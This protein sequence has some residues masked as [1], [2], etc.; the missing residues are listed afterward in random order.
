MKRA[1]LRAG[2][3]SL[4]LF[5]ISSASAQVPDLDTVLRFESRQ[6]GQILHGWGGGPAGTIFLDTT[7]VHSGSGAAHLVRKANSP[8]VFSTITKMVPADF[9][10]EWIELRGFLRT[11]NVSGFAGLWLRVDGRNGSLQFDNMYERSLKGTTEW[12]EYAVRLPLDS[13]A[14]EIFFGVLVEGEGEVWADDLQLTVEDK[15]VSEATRR[16]IEPTV[17]DTDREFDGGSG[18][19]VTTLTPLQT[20]NLAVLGKV[21]GF[22]KY[23]HP[24]VTAGEHHWDYELFRVLP[25]IL[26]ASDYSERNHTILAWIETIGIPGPC[27]ACAPEP[28]EPHLLP[29]LDWINDS[30][31][32]GAVL[33]GQLQTIYERR[34][35]DPEQFY[36]TQVSGVGNPVFEQELAYDAHQPPDAGFRFLSLLRLW[37]IVEYWFPYRDLLEDDWDAVLRDFLPRFTAAEG[38]DTYQLEVLSLLVRL[39]DTHANL[40]SALNLRPPRGD[41]RWPAA[42]R[43]AENQFVVA[44][45]VSTDSSYTPNLEIGDVIRA[46]DAIPVDSL[47]AEWSPYYAASNET[48]RLRDIARYMPRGDC[49]ES[50]VT[51]LRQGK[52]LTVDVPRVTTADPRPL[53]HDRPGQ[54]FQLLS[55]EV[56]YLKLSSVAAEDIGSYIERATGTDGLVI[57]IRNYPSEFVVFA[58]GSRLVDEPTPFARFTIGDPANPGAFVWTNPVS[59]EPQQPVYTGKVAILVDESSLSQAEYTAMALRAAPRSVVIGSRTAAADGNV[60]RIPLPGGI[61]GLITGIGVFYPDKTPTQRIGIVPDI[62][63]SPTV[64]GIRQGRD[65]VL[66]EAIRYILGDDGNADEIER[67]AMRPSP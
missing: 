64:E 23:H 53:P 60:S 25:E 17:L 42:L 15:P 13:N 45:H 40:W 26:E 61:Q 24:A 63:A 4:L 6:T 49:G 12:T 1:L 27:R 39:H 46:V 65:E 47:V 21:W 8:N 41:C 35:S 16:S 55:P 31:L 54:T 48:T 62:E 34:P 38:W 18:I 52:G 57:D 33:P 30:D 2:L 56:A 28:D 51:V 66:E 50:R 44:G 11:K 32:L 14:R 37:N 3:A 58:L 29:E 7:V 36:I 5:G 19:N 59:I 20:E 10:G 9:E 67:M 22:L 43:Y